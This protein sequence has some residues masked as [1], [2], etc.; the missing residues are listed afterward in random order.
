MQQ[1]ASAIRAALDFGSNT[2]EVLVARCLPG[3]L[4]IIEHQ[5]TMARLG[6]S[7]DE[8][9]EISRAKFA[10]VLDTVCK[11]QELA[12]KHGAEQ[13]FAVATEA[14]REAHNSQDLLEA[15]KH[16][17]GI[18]VQLISGAAVAVLDYYGQP[19]ALIFLPMREYWMWEAA[20]PKLSPLKIGISPG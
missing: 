19:M 1:Q 16:E 7:V 10:P 14:M 13:I 8:S 4:E 6:E 2:I 17:T 20:A 15:V 9:G 12:K 18:E 3:D 5:A 11:Y